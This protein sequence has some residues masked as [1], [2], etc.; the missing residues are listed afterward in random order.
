MDSLYLLSHR[1]RY[2]GLCFIILEG[3][4]EIDS[5]SNCKYLTTLSESDKK[6]KG[7]RYR[8]FGEEINKAYTKSRRT[9]IASST[10]GI[11]G[12]RVNGRRL[13]GKKPKIFL[14][15]CF[16]PWL[17]VPLP[18]VGVMVVRAGG[19]FTTP[20]GG[21]PSGFRDCRDCCVGGRFMGS[22][23]PVPGT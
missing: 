4:I 1:S 5:V 22:V 18:L 23:L 6:N 21:I 2:R 20:G 13:E 17:P 3:V 16:L 14:L 10:S 15:D 19:P 11:S 9:K 7:L 8:K 12:E